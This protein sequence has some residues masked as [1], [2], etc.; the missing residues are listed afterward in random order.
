MYELVSILKKADLKRKIVDVSNKISRDYQDHNLVLI[1]VLKGAF[2]FLAD[3]VRQLTIER[4]QIDFI[5]VASYGREM[6]SSG[7]IRLSKDID[8]DIKGM[9]VLLV[10]DIVDTGITLS[11]LKDHLNK[12]KPKSVKICTL[13]DKRE[14]R[15]KNI[16]VDYVCHVIEKDKGFIV[17][18]GLDYAENYR[19]L[20][21]LYDLKI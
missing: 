21:E 17:G 1:G 9:D 15:K 18:Y 14:R 10:E 5:S 6:E 11:F 16:E 4:V 20:P 7:V 3:L 2:I 19:N 12:F 8:I 13:I